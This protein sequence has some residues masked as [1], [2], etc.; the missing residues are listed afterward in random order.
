ITVARRDEIFLDLGRQSFMFFT[1]CALLLHLRGL[2]GKKVFACGMTFVGVTCGA[3]VL[4]SYFTYAGFAI[5]RDFS[6]YKTAAHF[7]QGIEL[8]PLSF[9]ALVGVLLGW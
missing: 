8:N 9:A 1:C 7:E 3:M 4:W 2:S 6:E 5:V